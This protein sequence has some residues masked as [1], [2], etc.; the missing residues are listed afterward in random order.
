M[1][2][3][4]GYVPGLDGIRGTAI[5][6]VLAYHFLGLPGGFY[7]V[8]L[9]FVLSGFLITTL[10]LEERTATG[11][12]SFGA[13]YARRARRLLPAL[14]AVLGVACFMAFVPPAGSGPGYGRFAIEGVLACL[15]YAANV[16]RMLGHL[17]PINLTPMW[18]LAEEEQFYFLWP[19]LFVLLSRRLNAGRLAVVLVA[20]AIAVSAW[21][22]GVTLTDG[23]T[24]RV[25]FGPDMRCSG[26]LLGSALA[27][28]R[29]AG[30]RLPRIPLGSLAALAVIGALAVF[31]HG[32]SEFA[33]A[34][35]FPLA[36]LAGIVL[37]LAALGGSRALMLPPLVWVG[38]VSYGV[39]VWM[40]TVAL[41]DRQGVTPL[42]LAVGAGWASTRFIE[43]RFRRRR[44]PAATAAGPVT[45]A[46]AA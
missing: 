32:S 2:T 9:F 40:A 23:A 6:L 24:G 41:F 39:Y 12:V 7:G 34:A 18:S 4:I 31:A 19:A 15:L 13:F 11:R 3:R 46:A 35:G 37:I 5:L 17:L 42:L 38:T 27:A 28:A 25:Y 22:A 16:F 43:R 8:D 14:V 10:L 26:L 33:Y 20:L 29:A 30:L 44:Q 21:R 1:S 45:A 36:E